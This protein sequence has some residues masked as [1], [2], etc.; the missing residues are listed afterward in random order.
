VISSSQR[1]VP[2]E[3]N[4]TY[5]HKDKHPCSE[6]DSN[7]RSQQPNDQD[8]RL[9]PRGR[10]YICIQC[11][12][13]GLS[14]ILFRMKDGPQPSLDFLTT[15]RPGHRFVTPGDRVTQL[16]SQALGT[17]FSRLLRHAWATLELFLSFGHHTEILFFQ[18]PKNYF[19]IHHAFLIRL[20]IRYVWYWLS[21]EGGKTLLLLIPLLNP[22]SFDG[23]QAILAL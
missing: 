19:D 13:V 2:T 6:R 11:S 16:Y 7:L 9:R 17:H 23:F 8:L 12:N 15:V 22:I 4:T 3:D 21:F 18:H 10:L 1:P 5:K 14:I 20:K